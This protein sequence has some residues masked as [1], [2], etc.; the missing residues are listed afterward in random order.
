MSTILKALRRLEDDK[1]VQDER[2]LR[3]RVLAG[4][5]TPET[6]GGGTNYVRLLVL[7]GG[8]FLL[9]GTGVVGFFFWNEPASETVV[10]E[11][12]EPVPEPK[13]PPGLMALAN[14]PRPVIRGGPVPQFVVPV[15]GAAP[16]SLAEP[17][18]A[19][20]VTEDI[21]IVTRSKTA[22][23]ERPES[24]P[25]A[26]PAFKSAAK[27]VAV[28]AAKPVA[29]PVAKPAAKLAAKPV[30]VPAAQP[31]AKP[32]AKLSPRKAPP[33]PR[34]ER[35]PI[36]EFVVT[37]TVWHPSAAR[38]VASVQLKGASAVQLISEGDEFGTLKVVEIQPSA[39]LFR[40]D[41]VEIKRRVGH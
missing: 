26:K 18:E 7:L 1:K 27:P 6:G 24:E 23:S 3:E 32:V 37:R 2:S 39:V 12:S 28:P 17:V 8:F 31:V 22:A 16:A 19:V 33:M 11:V 20:V 34:I 15:P 9:A 40:R 21:A 25:V 13:K 30:A 29:K 41:G 10:A 35:I 4:E 5:T 38:R 14:P 36:P